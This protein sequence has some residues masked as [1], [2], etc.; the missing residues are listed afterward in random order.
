[1][2]PFTFLPNCLLMNILVTGNTVRIRI[3]KYKVSMTIPAID[4]SMLTNQRE[5]GCGMIKTI[6]FTFYNPGL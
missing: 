5:F 1:M 6:I 2:T 3:G 4:G